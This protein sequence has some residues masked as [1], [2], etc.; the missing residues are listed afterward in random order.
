M[1]T[2]PLSLHDFIRQ[3]GG[4]EKPHARSRPVVLA[5][6]LL[7]FLALSALA[8][9]VVFALTGLQLAWSDFQPFIVLAVAMLGLS[10]FCYKRYDDKRLA[11]SA[12]VVGVATLA[13]LACGVLSNGGLRLRM[14]L[15]DPLLAA[16][17]ASAGIHVDAIVRWSVG[18]PW[19]I[20]ALGVIY[21][22]SHLIL[23]ALILWFIIRSHFAKVWELVA[24]VA[25]SMQIVAFV[26]ILMP[27]WGAMRHF[28]LYGLQG[29]GLP[30]GAGIYHSETFRSLY[31]GTDPLFTLDSMNGVV[32]FPSFHTVLALL[33]AQALW[34]T[35]LRWIATVLTGATIFSTIPIGGH[36][37]IDLVGG[38]AIWLGS[39]ML[40][41]R[42][43][44]GKA[45]AQ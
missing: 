8:S 15:S 42:L 7:A 29:N 14:P 22:A 36:Y 34:L 19:L 20:D 37:V 16:I 13:L 12:A 5:V 30:A 35:P 6:A 9:A 24:T 40:A 26:S 4:A 10:A 43:T 32:T 1:N 17:D 28:D 41:N 11:H 33:I 39:A 44:H 21:N 45:A 25:F 23:A 27:A 18:M 3:D 38:A 2:A 31:E